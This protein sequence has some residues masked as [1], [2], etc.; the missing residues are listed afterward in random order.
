MIAFNETPV[1]LSPEEQ[2]ANDHILSMASVV[3]EEWQ[4]HVALVFAKAIVEIHGSMPTDKEIAQWCRTLIAADGTHHLAWK[5]PDW[6]PGDMVDM[7]YVIASV[8]PPKP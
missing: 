2:L 4:N 6:K 3:S 1:G 8:P 7:S 5:A